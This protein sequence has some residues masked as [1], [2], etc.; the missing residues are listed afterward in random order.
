[1]GRTF[2]IWTDQKS[3]KHLLEQKISTPFQQF[4]VSKL[5]GFSYEIQYKSGVENVV[6]DALSRI[7]SSEP[8]LLAL[9][10]IHS[11]QMSLIEKAWYSDPILQQ[12]LQQKQHDPNA[13]PKFQLCEGQLRRNGRLVIGNDPSLKAKLLHW[14]HA[15][16]TRGHFGR[17]ATLK[18]LKHLFYWKGINKEVQQFIWQCSICQACKYDTSAQLSLLQPLP[19]PEEV[20]VDILMDFIEGLPK[21]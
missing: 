5:M 15:S 20:W 2:I 9:S 14:M 10:T 12:I 4:W 1:M 8:L 7:P 11:D 6:V 19:I 18:R 21:S 16:P 13:F 17:D 3:L